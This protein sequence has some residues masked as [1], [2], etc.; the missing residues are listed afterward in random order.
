MLQMGTRAMGPLLAAVLFVYVFNDTWHLDNVRNVFLAGMIAT[1]V[2][3]I[4]LFFYDDHMTLGWKSEPISRSQSYREGVGSPNSIAQQ[5]KQCVASPYSLCNN[6]LRHA[7]STL[8]TLSDRLCCD[9]VPLSATVFHAG[10]HRTCASVNRE[11]L[12]TLP[13]V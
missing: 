13:L 11:M 6:D 8:Y 12:H 5:S 1:T 2:P 9:S 3:A 10:T 4:L 7:V